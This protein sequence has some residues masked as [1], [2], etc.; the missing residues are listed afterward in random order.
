MR[1]C[2]LKLLSSFPGKLFV[3]LLEVHI[4]QKKD[5][6]MMGK[7]CHR[8]ARKKDLKDKLKKNTLSYQGQSVT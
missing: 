5:K 3:F 4:Q 8:D 1:K 7:E 6:L 2:V